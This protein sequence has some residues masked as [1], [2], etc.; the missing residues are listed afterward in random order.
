MANR[1]VQWCRSLYAVLDMGGTWTIPRTRL[2]F[3]KREGDLMVLVSRS[4]HMPDDIQRHEFYLCR[5][6]F[7]KA[8]ILM[9][10]E[11]GLGIR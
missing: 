9:H 2:T 4:P 7:A 1:H 10:D 6:N 3:E 8:G 5:R 11:T